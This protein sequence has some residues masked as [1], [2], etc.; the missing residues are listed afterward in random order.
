[1]GIRALDLI[2]RVSS[3][4]VDEI[5]PVA[6][7]S[8][9]GAMLVNHYGRQPPLPSIVVQA[10]PPASE[11]AI[12]QSLRED[13]ELLANFANC[14]E[15]FVKRRQEQELDAVV[16]PPLPEPQPAAAHIGVARLTP[17]P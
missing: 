1:M 4:F 12:A 17:K 5:L 15:E 6:T 9:I 11:N 10:Q 16:D 13:H 2:A 14:R 8:V 7:A 3:R